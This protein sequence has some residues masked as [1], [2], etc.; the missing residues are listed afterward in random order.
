LV[1]AAHNNTYRALI[2]T[3][4]DANDEFNLARMKNVTAIG[5]SVWK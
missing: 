1:K 3:L 5:S 4:E 2:K